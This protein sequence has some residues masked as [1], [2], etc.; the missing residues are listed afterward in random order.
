M[1]GSGFAWMPETAIQSELADGTL[2]RV[3]GDDWVEHLTIAAY[4]NPSQFD[5]TTRDLWDVL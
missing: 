1:A 4:A 5:K 2:V 3:G